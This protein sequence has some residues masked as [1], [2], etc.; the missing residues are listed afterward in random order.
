MLVENHQPCSRSI[1][2]I[3]LMPGVNRLDKKAWDLAMKGGYKKSVDGLVDDGTLSMV[4]DGKVTVAL[5]S[6]TYDMEI[7]EDWLV[8]A[9]GPVKGAIKKQIKELE[10]KESE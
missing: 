2:S 4:D 6:K 9:K 1:G 10:P 3:L 5:V 8:D 7:L